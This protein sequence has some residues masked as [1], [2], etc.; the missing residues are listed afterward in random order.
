MKFYPHSDQISHIPSHVYTHTFQDHNIAR[1]C[2]EIQWLTPIITTPVLEGPSRYLKEKI[3]PGI[4][5]YMHALKTLENTCHAMF[6][7]HLMYALFISLA[8]DHKA[9]IQLCHMPCSS[10]IYHFM[11][12]LFI[13]LAI[14]H[15][16]WIQFWLLLANDHDYSSMGC[17]MIWTICH[18]VAQNW[19]VD[20]LLS[21]S[22]SINLVSRESW[23]SSCHL[24]PFTRNLSSEY[25][26]QASYNTVVVT[27]EVIVGVEQSKTPNCYY[28]PEDLKTVRKWLNQ[29]LNPSW[30]VHPLHCLLSVSECISN[31]AWRHNPI[32]H[33]SLGVTNSPRP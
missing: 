7:Y 1:S 16:A 25:N 2:Y 14:D 18:T 31:R 27:C 33:S 21:A 9:W 23:E 4:I 28:K 30:S 20:A 10:I 3:A 8:I 13:S 12:T 5:F 11:H 6:I 19:L 15:K 32:L 24:V 26:L 29:G 22:S 17:R